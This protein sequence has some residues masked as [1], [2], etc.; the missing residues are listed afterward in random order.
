[1]RSIA[2]ALG[3]APSTVTREVKA[4]GDGDYGVWP[5]HVR[6][7]E[8]AKRPKRGKLSDPVLCAKVTT[9]LEKF[10]SP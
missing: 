10:W 4:N 3:R 7:R 2:R 9:W 5:A 6:A 8:C 1:M